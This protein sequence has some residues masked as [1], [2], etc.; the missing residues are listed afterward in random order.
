MANF[1]LEIDADGI[2]LITWDMPGRSMNV[3]DMGVM[4]EL[5]GLVDKVTTDAAIKGAVIT[6]G[7]EAFCGGADLTMLEKHGRGLC[8]HRAQ[9]RRGS[10][11]AI[12]LRRKPQAVADLSRAG[13]RRQAVGLRAQRHR[14]GRRLRTRARL[15]S[16]HRRRQSEDAARPARDQ[17]RPVPR[18]RRHPAR[19]AHDPARR[20]AA[21]S[22]QGRPAQ[23]RP[24]QGDEADRQRRAAGRSHQGGEGLDQGRRQGGSAVGREGLQAAGRA[25]LFQGRHDDVPAGQR[26]LPARD[27]R[28]LS[29]RARHPAG[30][31]R[32][33]AIGH[34]HR[35]ARRV[36]LVRQDPAL[37]GSGRHDPLAVRLHAGAQQGRPP[38]RPTCRRPT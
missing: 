23:S 29:G 3:I 32:G 8:R 5:S 13:K 18:R 16:P 20:R 37:A 17:D 30:G 7:K 24:R 1:K 36:A 11:R 12:R 38:S 4:D 6:S 19:G 34:G 33:P 15:P 22:A 31:L 14:H 10:R 2:A 28:Q 27:L 35:A 9:Q 25:G 21:I 26:D